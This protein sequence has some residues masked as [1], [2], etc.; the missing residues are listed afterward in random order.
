M[1]DVK[2]ILE[3]VEKLYCKNVRHRSEL[4]NSNVNALNYEVTFYDIVWNDNLSSFKKHVDDV[5]FEILKF[6]QSNYF[7]KVI[8]VR[9]EINDRYKNEGA[10]VFINR[11]QLTEIE[12]NPRTA[13][14]ASVTS[15]NDIYV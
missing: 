8:R 14:L 7:Y 15:L 5:N 13:H 1:N 6:V 3:K 4:G 10:S 2:A 12:R 9:Q 11:V